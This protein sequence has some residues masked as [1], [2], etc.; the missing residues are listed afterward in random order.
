MKKY[1]VLFADLD[2]TLIDTISG[3]TFPKG[4]WD[5]RIRFD[6][7]DAIKKLKPLCVLIVTNQGGIESG[8]V[9]R[10][11]FE[12]KMEYIVR[13]IKEYVGCYTE[14]S[15]CE[16]NDKVNHYRKP[17][18]GMLESMLRKCQLHLFRPDNLTKDDCLMIGDASGKEGQFSDSDKKTAENFGIDYMDV[19][20]FVKE[21]SHG[22]DIEKKD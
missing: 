21:M 6:V 20:D 3:D 7:L 22:R 2:G 19:E 15:Y 10:R 12:F 1:K 13:S 16:S 8:F 18:I 11:D 4:I 9:N 5:M 14:Y 17:N